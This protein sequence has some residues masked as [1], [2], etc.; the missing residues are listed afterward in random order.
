MSERL[1]RL[2]D[3]GAKWSMQNEA[4]EHY[5]KGLPRRHSADCLFVA[6]C[7]AAVLGQE[8]EAIGLLEEAKAFFPNYDPR[9]G[10]VSDPASRALDRFSRRHPEVSWQDIHAQLSTESHTSDTGTETS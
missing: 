3:W 2:Y 10:I 7:Y 6:A 1:A 9:R 5:R 4:M 8:P